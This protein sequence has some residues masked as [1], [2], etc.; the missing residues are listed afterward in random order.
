MQDVNE[1]ISLA[2]SFFNDFSM[3]LGSLFTYEG[4]QEIS[5]NLWKNPLAVILLLAVVVKFFTSGKVN[6]IEG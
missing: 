5:S 4:L 1:Y 3:S 6:D 2:N